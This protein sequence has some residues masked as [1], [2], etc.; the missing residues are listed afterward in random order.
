M[1]YLS[2]KSLENNSNDLS[3]FLL[4]GCENGEVVEYSLKDPE[5]SKSK[6]FIN[7]PIQKLFVSTEQKQLFLLTSDQVFVKANY[8]LL[9]KSIDKVDNITFTPGYCQELL[10]IK[11]IKNDP[12]VG[13][14]GNQI[15]PRLRV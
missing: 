1:F 10:D 12:S 3:P 6:F 11:I 13:N 9:K 15:L 7:Q 14:D 4:F 5:S 2:R 8:D